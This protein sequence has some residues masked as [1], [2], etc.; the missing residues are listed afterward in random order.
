MARARGP[1]SGALPMSKTY[2][3]YIMAS[4]RNGTLYIGVTND[5]VRRAG[6]HR[7]GLVEGFSKKYGCKLLVYIETYSDI[8]GAIWRETRLKKW[9]R[10]WKIGLIE[11][12]NPE[13]QDL[14][15][16]FINDELEALPF[17]ISERA[18]TEALRWVARVRGP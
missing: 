10:S 14:Y 7:D 5:V 8:S 3:V 15:P 6:E 9:K 4:R 12:V 13:W 2:F 11:E 17:F 1:P 16:K 18:G